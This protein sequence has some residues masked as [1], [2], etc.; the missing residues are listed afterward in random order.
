[1]FSASLRFSFSAD[2]LSY[3]YRTIY[4]ALSRTYKFSAVVR[5][6]RTPS[7]QDLSYV[8]HGVRSY[9][10]HCYIIFHMY[11]LQEKLLDECV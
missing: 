10:L 9:R 1:M 2:A 8:A 3:Y 4:I 5:V 11:A 6:Y 7:Q